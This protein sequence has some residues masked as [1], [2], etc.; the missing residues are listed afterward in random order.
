VEA[1]RNPKLSEYNKKTKLRWARQS[2]KLYQTA[3]VANEFKYTLLS[4]PFVYILQLNE[5][6]LQF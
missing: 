3:Y 4:L 5:D 1:I 6:D 2:V